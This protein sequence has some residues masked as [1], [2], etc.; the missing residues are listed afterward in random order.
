MAFVFSSLVRRSS[1]PA[2]ATQNSAPSAARRATMGDADSALGELNACLGVLAEM[3]PDLQPEVFREMLASFSPESRVQVVTEQLL[4]DPAKWVGGRFRMPTE[5][6]EQLLAARKTH[7]RYRPVEP[8]RDTR[9]AP[10]AQHDRFRSASYQDAARDALC[11]E[12]KSLSSAT[13]KAVL[14]E[15][16]WSYTQARP[17]LLALA[18]TSWRAAI[19]NFF[20]RRKPPTA[21]DHPLVVWLA[22]D[23]KTG[24]PRTP[25]LVKTRSPELD[26]ELY[27]TLVAPELDRQRH[28]QVRE[29]H[30]LALQWNEH[31]AEHEGELYDCECCFVPNTLQQMSTCDSDAHYICFRCIRHATNAAL[32]DQG[33]SRNIDTELC[34][35]RCIAPMASGGEECMGCIPFS[36]VERALLEETDGRD[37]L[38]KLEERFSSDTL[39]KSGFGLIR[40]PFCTYAEINDCP[41]WDATLFSGLRLR[42][43]PSLPLLQALSR[44]LVNIGIL[45][46]LVLLAPL[47]MLDIPF[48]RP[49]NAAVRRI[50]LKR[51]GLRFTCLSPAC[52]RSS[53]LSCSAPWHD[54][55]SCFTSQLTSLRLAIERATTDAIKRTCPNCNLSFVKSEGC[56]KLVCVCGYSMCYV[57][58]EGMQR[59]GYGHFCQHF[60]AVPGTACTECNKCDLYREESKDEAIERAKEQAEQEWWAAQ[61]GHGREGLQKEVGN[62]GPQDWGKWIEKVIE[63]AVM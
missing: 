28:E 55:H 40:C 23:P 47:I 5:H 33:W 6:D 60:R 4:K 42:P 51:R 15:Y 45:Y 46:L 54:P 13:V 61:G 16:N 59:Q 17:T 32:Y 39:L 37:S 58:R 22:P 3:F 63:G 2:T 41:R 62:G 11:R 52:G 50:N 31:E 12:F 29:D 48:F 21:H 18:S 53:C 7:F 56:N 57:C 9:G 24:R 49:V 43:R 19:A 8:P 36:F 27:D 20:L 14:A 30:A 1:R 38:Q 35:L 34:T 44:Q 10:L 25:L 26:R